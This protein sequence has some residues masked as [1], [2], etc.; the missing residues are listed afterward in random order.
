MRV[1]FKCCLI[2]MGAAGIL[3]AQ[4][5]HGGGGGGSRGGGGGGGYHASASRSTSSYAT[6]NAARSVHPNPIGLQPYPSGFTGINRGA[7]S[8]QIHYGWPPTTGLTTGVTT[9]ARRPVFGYPPVRRPIRYGYYGFGFYPSQG[10]GYYGNDWGNNW[11]DPYYDSGPGVP[12]ASP[13]QYAPYAAMPDPNV[14]TGL[15]PYY[16]P[17]PYDAGPPQQQYYAPSPDSA[18]VPPTTPIVLILKNGQKLEV[19]NY[20]IMNG[21]FWDFTK[22]NS[23]RFP[24]AAIDA[25]AS[26]RAT[27]DAGGSFPEESFAANQE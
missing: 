17:V 16:P 21:M 26:A 12:Y 5:G 20:A 4:H 8:N 19:Q 23:K 13:D 27:E 24:L 9:G 2:A 1:L 3:A 22:Q 10:F 18:P 15:G 6:P 7:Y 11:N 14:E 25:G